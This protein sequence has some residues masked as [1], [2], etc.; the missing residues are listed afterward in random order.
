MQ[1]ILQRCNSYLNWIAIVSLP[2]STTKMTSSSMLYVSSS[3]QGY[4]Y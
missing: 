2:V 4:L 1:V 3:I